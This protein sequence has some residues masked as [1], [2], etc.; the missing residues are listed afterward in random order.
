MK[1]PTTPQPPQPAPPSPQPG[2]QPGPQSEQ[3]TGLAGQ[4]GWIALLAILMSGVVLMSSAPM[5]WLL[6]PMALSAIS[7]VL[8]AVIL[9]R[10]NKARVK[11]FMRTW[12][13]IMIVFASM[14]L[15]FSLGTLALQPI[16]GPF[17]DCIRE[18]VTLSGIHECQAEYTQKIER[19][20]GTTPR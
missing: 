3:P 12:T 7:I 19:M 11:G 14:S 2:S 20:T 17:R 1:P 13:V 9:S 8:A 16:L 10:L 5:P 15:L 4:G 18:S 6:L